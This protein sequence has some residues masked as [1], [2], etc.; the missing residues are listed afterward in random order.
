MI[1]DNKNNLL[2]L[3]FEFALIIIDY[4]ELLNQQNNSIIAKQLLISGTKLGANIREAQNSE[5]KAD[6]INKLV[7][8]LK[9]ADKTEYWL[10]LCKYSNNKTFNENIL[11]QLLEIKEL[12]TKKINSSI[13]KFKN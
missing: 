5:S 4:S 2:N 7:I 3:S 8:A 12:S 9:E 11:K 6:Y 13:Y 1:I 10:E